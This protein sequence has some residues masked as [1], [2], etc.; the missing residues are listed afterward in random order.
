MVCH[1][2]LMNKRKCDVMMMCLN[3]IQPITRIYHTQLKTN[4][5]KV[6]GWK[7]NEDFEVVYADCLY[8]K[9]MLDHLPELSKLAENVNRADNVEGRPTVASIFR[10]VRQMICDHPYYNT[11]KQLT[12][13][14]NYRKLLYYVGTV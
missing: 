3:G 10:P 4:I 13:K 1:L 5:Q 9:I 2:V 14:L 11:R 6:R 7:L 8:N 12:F